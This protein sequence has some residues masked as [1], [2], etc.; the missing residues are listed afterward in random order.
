MRSLFAVWLITLLSLTSLSAVGQPAHL[1]HVTTSQQNLISCHPEEAFIA[2]EGSRSLC[3]R[4][5]ASLRITTD[6]PSITVAGYWELVRD[7]QQ[8]VTK[9]EALSEAEARQQ[10][11]DLASQWEKVTAVESPDQGMVQIDSSYLVAELRNVAPD[12][13]RL[14]KLLDALLSAHADYPQNVFT[15]QDVQP[16]QEILTR[17]EFQWSEPQ[18]VT[19]PNWLQKIIDAF[20]KFMDRIA[21]YL[22]NSAYYGRVPLI[23]AAVIIFIISLYF[24]SRNLSRNLVRDAQLAAEDGGDA[25]LS[26]KGAMQR[27]QILS[28]QGD[29]RTAI[30]YLYLSSLL[31]LDEQGLL[32]YDRS[33]TN[34][35]YLRSVASRP[36]LANPLRSVIDLFDRVWYGFDEVDE[37]T[38]QAYV[39]HVEKL[40]ENKE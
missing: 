36:I 28:T 2:T 26:S 18:A 20:R 35:E 22:L 10:L 5:F 30:R 11:D 24:I 23:I 7:T 19:A 15:I 4:F 21:V 17:P 37:K 8:A 14:E 3:T 16:L 25:L 33:R 38:Y 12:L 1:H 39:A 13:Q 27:A 9:M 29:Y 32:R 31:T 34:R 40:R 6:E